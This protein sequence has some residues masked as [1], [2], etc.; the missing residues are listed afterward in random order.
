MEICDV[1][2]VDARAARAAFSNIIIGAILKQESGVCLLRFAVLL[3]LLVKPHG[4]INVNGLIALTA[5]VG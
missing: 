4:K 1:V 2:K 5:G 3:Q